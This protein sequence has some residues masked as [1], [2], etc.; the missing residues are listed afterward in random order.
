MLLGARHAAMLLGRLSHAPT[1]FESYLGLPGSPLE[2]LEIVAAALTIIVIVG[3]TAKGSRLLV[4]ERIVNLI[5]ERILEISLDATSAHSVQK[6]VALRKELRQ[7]AQRSWWHPGQLDKSRWNDLEEMI[8]DR[9]QE[10]RATRTKALLREVQ[11]LA[12]REE[13]AAIDSAVELRRRVWLCTQ[14]GEMSGSQLELVLRALDDHVHTP[15]S[16]VS[17]AA[18]H[19]APG[20]ASRTLSQPS[21]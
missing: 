1:T 4:R 5:R 15:T 18:V 21:K 10:A 7:R 20:V 14:N 16:R 13:S 19:V 12:E 8:E 9:I 11:S 17:G 3:G 6:L 2:W